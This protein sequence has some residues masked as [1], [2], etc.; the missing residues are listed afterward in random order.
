MLI[1]LWLLLMFSFLL[2]K[3]LE[4]SPKFCQILV[5][6]SDVIPL[7]VFDA[8]SLRNPYISFSYL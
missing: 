8:R 5:S 1:L 3:Y 7:V 4:F 2:S 6:P